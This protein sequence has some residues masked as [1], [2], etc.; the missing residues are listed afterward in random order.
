MLLIHITGPGIRAPY[1]NCCKGISTSIKIQRKEKEKERKKIIILKGSQH[2][3]FA[4]F[5]YTY[6][7]VNRNKGIRHTH[8]NNN[9]DLNS[10]D[11]EHTNEQEKRKT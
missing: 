1:V 3:N 2:V 6:I 8:V 11:D 7:I 5:I 10:N 9:V 4:R